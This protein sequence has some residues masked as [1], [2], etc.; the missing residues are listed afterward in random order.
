MIV[1]PKQASPQ[2][3][4]E[5][6]LGRYG[7][8]FVSTQLVDHVDVPKLPEKPDR[9]AV[10]LFAY[11]A[12][13]ARPRREAEALTEA[14]FQ[15]DVISLRHKS[16]DPARETINGVNVVLAPL[17]HRRGGKLSY[18]LEYG[19]FFIYAFLLL[20][21]WSMKRRYR[22]VHVHN[23]PD[24]LVFSAWLPRLR[25]AKVVLDLHDP[26]PE[27]FASMYGLPSGHFA[28]WLL[29][30]IEKWSTGF[31]DL[32]VTPNLAFKELFASR[33]CSADK[34][35]IVMNTPDTEL[36]H[37]HMTVPVSAASGVRPFKLMYHGLLVKRHGMDLAI[38]AMACLRPRIPQ[39]EMHLYGEQTQFMTW[40]MGEVSQWKLEEAVHYHGY[41]PLPEIA[42][43]IASIDLGVIPNRL[44]SFTRINLPTR[45]FEYLAM[46][47][48]VIAPRTQ[49]I[50]DYF[51]DEE[52]IYFEPGNVDDLAR[53]MEWVY[54]HPAETRSVVERGRKVYKKYSWELERSRWTGLVKGLG[55]RRVAATAQG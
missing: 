20:S 40:L 1:A 4:G 48:P 16:S 55:P 7:Q 5:L 8:H 42:D 36:F 14:G 47:K 30:R 27:I 35:E 43:A 33:G 53:K 11:Y 29:R 52:I 17:R 45:I 15:V 21:K 23:M 9:A 34:I 28:P 13:D 18:V 26:M 22:V 49:G 19:F 10:V 37:E 3:A 39:I 32:V 6:S 51:K 2:T 54:Q 12:T 31:A 24:F 50:A 38:Q 44:N 41:K 46:G 25:G